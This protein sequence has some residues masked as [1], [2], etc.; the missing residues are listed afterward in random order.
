MR[1]LL[2]I[3]FSVLLVTGG[4][5][6]PA[7]ANGRLTVAVAAN[8]IRP[9]AEIAEIFFQE[10]GI[11]IETSYGA[12][13][14][15]YAQILRGA[16]FDVFLAADRKRPR[17]LH[18]QGLG[19]EPRTYARGRV[20]LWTSRQGFAHISTWQ[21]LLNDP[22]VVRI[23]IPSPETAPYG[24]AAAAA[25]KAA[26]LWDRLR[27]KLVYGQSVAQAF[28][29]GVSR[30]V[31]AAFVSASYAMSRQGRRGRSFPIAEAGPI[32]QQA[33]IVNSGKNELAKIFLDFLTA[34][35]M[36]PLLARYGYE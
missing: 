30:G 18:E 26:A 29:F 13:G 11:R 36:Q 28:Q 14:K 27:E 23:A 33:C 19:S 35:R 22:T 4:F 16:P 1:Y 5:T 6:A 17:L 8:F 20:V 7:S 9:M 24:A 3:I 10:T 31:D 12:T 25:L 34:D 32:I 2:C 21:E 15:L